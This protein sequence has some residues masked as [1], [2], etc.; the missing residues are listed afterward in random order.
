M[1]FEVFAAVGRRIVTEITA[2]RTPQPA[3]FPAPLLPQ[4]F[5]WRRGQCQD[6]A[7]IRSQ[8]VVMK[9]GPC[10]SA[11][12]LVLLPVLLV[13]LC[14]SLF[15]PRGSMASRD[16][17]CAKVQLRREGEICRALSEAMEWTWLGHAIIAPGW[18]LTWPGLRRVYCGANIA[19]ADIPA[20]E[21][22]ARGSDWRLESGAGNLLRLVAASAGTSDEPETS[23]FNPQN[24]DYL[25]KDGCVH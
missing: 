13:V 20:L 5:K 16:I 21:T 11:T 23:I 3:P 22:L 1:Q 24:P 2:D 8:G 9:R 25:L 4:R 15:W 10:V 12:L 17:G 14:A 18:R 7:K 6:D 19:A